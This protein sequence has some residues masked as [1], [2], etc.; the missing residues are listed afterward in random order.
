MTAHFPSHSPRENL[1]VSLPP[2][3][4]RLE[5]YFLI[6]TESINVFKNRSRSQGIY[7]DIE[8]KNNRTFSPK[9]PLAMTLSNTLILL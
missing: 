9:M 4:E 2:A 1:N 7:Q 8:F 3:Q 5:M 6:S